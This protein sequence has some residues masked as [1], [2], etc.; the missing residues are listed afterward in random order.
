WVKLNVDGSH[1]ESEGSTAIGGVLREEHGGWLGGFCAWIGSPGINHAEMRAIR[2]GIS[3][4][5]M[6]GYS[7]LEVETDSLLAVQLLNEEDVVGHPLE[8]FVRDIRNLQKG[9]WECRI[10]HVKREAN[11]VADSFAKMGHGFKNGE[12]W[13]PAPPPGVVLILLLFCFNFFLTPKKLDRFLISES[14]MP[15][16]PNLKVSHFT[17]I[18][19][20]HKIIFLCLLPPIHP[21]VRR[22]FKFDNRLLQNAELLVL[23]QRIWYSSFYGL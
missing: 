15:V 22:C 20:D 18:V 23:V 21:D 9:G 13:F 2:D 8:N 3:W 6:F 16:Y 1:L 5:R 19:S 12:E 17:D 11:F 4:V 14:L 10:N 7:R